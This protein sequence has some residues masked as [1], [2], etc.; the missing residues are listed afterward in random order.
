M[1]RS[2]VRNAGHMGRFL[3]LYEFWHLNHFNIIQSQKVTFTFF[4]YILREG[5]FE[6]SGL[7]FLIKVKHS[8]VSK[9]FACNYAAGFKCFLKS[10][11]IIIQIG[12][13]YNSILPYGRNIWTFNAISFPMDLSHQPNIF[14]RELYDSGTQL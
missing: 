5:N 14:H 3:S 10:I 12:F 8:S 6:T 2:E 13:S 1:V 11:K 4:P 9:R 7:V